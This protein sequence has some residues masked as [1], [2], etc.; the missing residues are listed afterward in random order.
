MIFNGEG[1][2]GRKQIRALTGIA[3]IAVI[4]LFLGGCCCGKSGNAAHF[5]EAVEGV[6]IFVD[7]GLDHTITRVAVLPFK[8]PTDLIGTAVSDMFITEV[9]RYGRYT[10]VERSQI[11]KVLGETELA[12]AGVSSARAMDVGQMTGADGV[13][14]GTVYEYEQIAYKGNKYPAAGINVRLIDSKSGKIVW[15]AD[16]ASRGEDRA[17]SLSQHARQVVHAICSTLYQKVGTENK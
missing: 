8:G 17:S 9:L 12:L 2:Q 14:I 4:P 3:A 16:Y 11:S 7:A 10:L 1:Q 6:N 15:S 13:I 5:S